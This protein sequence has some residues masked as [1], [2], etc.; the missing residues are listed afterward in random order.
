MS[1]DRGLRRALTTTGTVA[2]ALALCFAIGAAR[3]R[4]VDLL[5]SALDVGANPGLTALLTNSDPTTHVRGIAE[6][7]SVPTAAQV[8]ALKGLGL[9]VQAMKHVPLA[10]VS[11]TVAQM[12]S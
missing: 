8:A 11:G 1:A 5:P 9:T 6:F 4:A 3:V 7:S 2:M 10:L 12:Q